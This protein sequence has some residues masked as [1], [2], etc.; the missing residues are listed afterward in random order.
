MAQEAYNEKN[1]V[2]DPSIEELVKLGYTHIDGSTISTNIDDGDRKTERDV[3][4]HKVLSESIRRINPWITDENQEKVVREISNIQKPTLIEAN[5]LFWKMLVRYISVDQD[6]GQ[7]RKGQT[8]KVVDFENLNNNV[9]HVV[10]ELAIRGDGPRPIRTDILLYVN[11]IPL[12]VIECKS[13]TISDPIDEAIDQL[14]Y[15]ANTRGSAEP[16]GAQKLFFYNAI[17]IADCRDHCYLGTITSS[18]KYFLPWKDTF[19]YYKN[20]LGNDP[21]AQK[22]VN[23]CVLRP[24]ALLDIIQNFTVFDREDGTIIKKIPRYQQ[25]RA[26]MKS[27]DRVLTGEDRLAKGGV[28]WHTQGSGKSLTMVFLAQKFRSHKELQKYK[29][30]FITDRTSLDDQLSGTMERC[31]DET[32]LRAKSVKD[33]KELLKK[34]ASDLITGMLQKFQENDFEEMQELNTSDKILILVDEA[35]RGQ[36]K[37]LASNMRVALPN[38]PII[39]FTGTPLVK[40]DKQR[41]IMGEYIDVYT[42]EQAVGDG[43]TV[44]II[45]EGRESKTKVT[46]DNLETLFEMHFSDRTPEE[47]DAI[48]KKYGREQAVLEAPSRIEEICKD[49]IEHYNSKIKPDGFKAQLVVGSRRAA[50]LYHQAMNR[51]KGP[52]SAVIISGNHKDDAF[53]TPYTDSVKQKEQIRKFK[54]PLDKDTLSFLIVKDK[55]L[56]GFDA[57]IEQV[58]YID[59]KLREHSL[60]QAI[61]RVNRTR[62]GKHCG[63]I[64]DYYGLTDY[65]E[66]A[67]RMFSSEDIRGALVPLK[68]EIPKL[69]TRHRRVLSYFNDTDLADIDGCVLRLKDEKIRAEFERDF[70]K[71]LSSMNIILPD[72]SASSFISDMKKLGKINLSARNRYRVPQL[73]IKDAGEKVREIIDQHIISEGVDPKI[74]PVELFSSDFVKSLDNIKDPESKACEIEFAIRSHIRSNFEDDPA[75]YR[76]LSEKLKEILEKRRGHWDELLELLKELRNGIETD[77]T[78]LAD[79]LGLSE[80]ELPFYNALE[81]LILKKYPEKSENVK[82]KAELV[83]ITTKLVQVLQDASKIVGFI[84]KPE[85]VKKAKRE[86]KHALMAA[87]EFNGEDRLLITRITEEFMNLVKRKFTK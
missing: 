30:V 4:L 9:F 37:S 51:L 33:L 23:H 54:E 66:D 45:Y 40:D 77:R 19:P 17:M 55:L 62:K 71:F 15:Y 48:V 83:S 64:V 7:G 34:D 57:P 39:G 5:E 76:K 74:P 29:M 32:V 18:P 53:Y 14:R 12:V 63:Y 42:I 36:F 13:P 20:E 78:Q 31:Q 8:V 3:I 1:I 56:T 81:E 21:K 75:Y 6:L 16:E 2:Q 82:L 84:G 10:D 27:V 47:R 38:A 69:E 59:R 58:M 52:E 11:G 86:I 44:Q 46:G 50:V 25:Y 79:D 41:N 43:A 80:L 67:L 28:V 35:H 22:I 61:A 26:V 24:E 73:G 87:Q 85:K 65:L 60:L 49:I 72:P 68:E 70:K